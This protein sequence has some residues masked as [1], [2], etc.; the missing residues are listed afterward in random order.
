MRVA[1][2]LQDDPNKNQR[3]D[4]SAQP[5]LLTCTAMIGIRHIL[6]KDSC[7]F[8]KFMSLCAICFPSIYV[9]RAC[10]SASDHLIGVALLRCT[11]GSTSCDCSSGGN[12][13]LQLT[14]PFNLDLLFP[15]LLLE[16]GVSCCKSLGSVSSLR[17]VYT[18]V[19]ALLTG[20]QLKHKLQKPPSFTGARST[21]VL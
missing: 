21:V 17:L 15:V 20:I 7:P 16:F 10:L 1:I 19:V 6:N 8:P 2:V 9:A 4:T 12:S 5:V 13:T 3:K 11:E 18:I 14:H